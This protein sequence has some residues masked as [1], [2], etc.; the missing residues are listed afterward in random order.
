MAGRLLITG[1]SS[2]LGRHLVPLALS[3]QPAGFAY[4][5]YS[6]DPLGLPSGQRLD[7]RDQA[8][9]RAL[10]EAFR[11]DT[12]IHLAG[13]NRPAETM[14]AVIRQGANH[15]V[16]AARAHGARLIHLSTDVIFDGQQAPYHEGD[17][18][19]PLHAYGRA[20][21]AAEETVSRYPEHVI[22]RTSLI[23]GLEEMDRGTEWIHEAL[24]NGR[25][26]T[27]FTDQIRNPVWAPALSNACLELVTLPYTGILHVAGA[28]QLSRAAFGTRMLDWW[29]VTRREHLSFGSSDP[30]RWPQNCTLAIER[31]TSLLQTPLPGVDAVL[32]RAYE[33]R[34]EGAPGLKGR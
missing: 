16:E 5:Y 30:A 31:A 15:V 26:V 13:S 19:R 22:V 24:A 17:S 7:I 33:Q 3:R 23:Y 18:P 32:A 9:V 14:E 11:P 21:A 8:A 10:V 20:K 27:L 2:Y 34:L 4:T 6:N 28:Q 29:G 25:P 1:G 12:I